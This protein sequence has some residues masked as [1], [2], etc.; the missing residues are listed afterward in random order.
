MFGISIGVGGGGDVV[1]DLRGEGMVFVHEAEVGLEARGCVGWGLWG[2][3]NA[4]S[5]G[6]DVRFNGAG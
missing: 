6:G 5:V 3:E 1:D 4:G 2:L